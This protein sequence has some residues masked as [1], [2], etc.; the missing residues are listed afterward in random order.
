VERN[1]KKGMIDRAGQIVVPLRF[2]DLQP[3]HDGLAPA[4]ILPDGATANLW[5]F[6][7]QTGAFVI[8]PQYDFADS[9]RQE[10]AKV[11]IGPK[12]ERLFGIIDTDGKYIL[13]PE[14]RVVQSF[15]EGLCV[16]GGRVL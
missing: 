5:G 14:Y 12:S 4:A 2:V 15:A 8:A 7:D 1:T 11:G 10:R 13:K 6:I 16:A 9:F 3:F